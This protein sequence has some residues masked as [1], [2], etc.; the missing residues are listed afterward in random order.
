VRYHAVADH[1]FYNSRVDLALP[2]LKDRERRER[3]VRK[4]DMVDIDLPGTS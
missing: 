2:G 3:D 4:S 1:L